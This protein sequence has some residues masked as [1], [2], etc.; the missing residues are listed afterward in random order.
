MSADI[1]ESERREGKKQ[2]PSCLEE[3]VKKSL[4][5][6]QPRSCQI[7][8][9]LVRWVN[10]IPSLLIFRYLGGRGG[11]GSKAVSSSGDVQI[12]GSFGL[13]HGVLFYELCHLLNSTQLMACSPGWAPKQAY[14]LRYK[15]LGKYVSEK[16]RSLYS[17]F[18]II[19]RGLC[20]LCL[21][22]SAPPEPRPPG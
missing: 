11:E 14:L 22:R 9:L 6:H 13:R 10:E 2:P 16:E 17:F 12:R 19:S 15:S 3:G 4:V 8:E 5:R 18:L 1:K 20:G 21:L 7:S